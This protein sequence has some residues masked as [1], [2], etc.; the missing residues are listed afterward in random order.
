MGGM[1]IYLCTSNIIFYNIGEFKNS[2]LIYTFILNFMD[3]NQMII[4]KV[5]L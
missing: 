2:T 3:A 1:T 5:H 4:L